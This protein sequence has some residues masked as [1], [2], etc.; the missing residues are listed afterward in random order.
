MRMLGQR[1]LWGI[2][3]LAVLAA[4]MQLSTLY[5]LRQENGWLAE[6]AG[7]H[8]IDA[9]RL[10]TA[11]PEVRLARALYL[12]GHKRYDEALDTLNQVW[13][14]G[15]A[16]LQA[17]AR[18]AGGN[19]FLER[20]MAELEAGRMDQAMPLLALAKQAYRAALQID[21]GF[22]EAKYNLETASRL[23]PDF[24]RIDSGHEEDNSVRSTQLWTTVPGFPRGLP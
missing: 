5:R 9:G 4:S 22:W 1:L 12:H 13:T 17:L 10:A 20:A 24:D 14:R 23:L 16:P 2:W 18:Y 3:L 6:L 15:D 11:A 19:I 8:D 7:G 21:S